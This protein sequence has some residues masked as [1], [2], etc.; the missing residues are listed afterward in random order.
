MAR[1]PTGNK[2]GRNDVCW[3]DSGRKFKHC[4]LSRDSAPPVHA[5][6]AVKLHEKAYTKSY[7]SCPDEWR[8]ECNGPIVRAHT[9]SRSSSLELIAEDGHV[10]K[11][12]P[13]LR[14]LTLKGRYREPLLGIKRASTF[15]GFCGAHDSALFRSV[16]D[17][18]VVWD[19]N[20]AF[21]LS[22]RTLC[23]E[24]FA[25]L[26]AADFLK[27]A[28]GFDRGMGQERQLLVQE[29]VGISQANTEAANQSGQ[30]L[31]RRYDQ[32]LLT[33][34]SLNDFEHVT[35]HFK[36]EPH[37]AISGGFE[38]DTD[39]DGQ[40]L[41]DLY[42]FAVDPEFLNLNVLPSKDGTIVSMGWAS[43]QRGVCRRFVE[44]LIADGR[45]GA[46][47]FI[48]LANIEN[49][50]VR[51]SRWKGLPSSQIAIVRNLVRCF[52]KP[53]RTALRAE[54]DWLVETFSERG[55]RRT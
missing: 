7:C 49:A 33:L 52:E 3:C 34:P 28:R 44:T 53:S 17:P 45:L 18:A 15:S 13:D 48:G 6:Q 8:H 25:K 24:R 41:Q 43:D 9:V 36:D 5:A 29:S 21:L 39:L 11:L 4:H 12:A 55:E 2:L 51:P 27:D 38:P 20:A 35:F 31:K 54:W 50:F 46:F 40:R 47:V 42:D 22:Y 32:L 10:I 19:R 23:R 16:D 30:R 1:D 26:C 37:V 14:E